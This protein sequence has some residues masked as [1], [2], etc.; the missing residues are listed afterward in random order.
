MA[1]DL[2]EW[3]VMKGIPFREAHSI[4][5]KIVVILEEKGTN[6]KELTLEM[7]KEINPVFDEF[8]LECLDITTAL[9]R[10]KTYG[11]TNPQ[12]V[13]KR[14]QFWKRKIPLS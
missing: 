10:K 7:L 12:Q 8:A 4:V 9:K 5:G 3:L 11:S 6:F 2:A 13:K 1:T 14:I